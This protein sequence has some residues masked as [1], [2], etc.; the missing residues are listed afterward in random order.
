MLV[1]ELK[2][3]TTT[4][5][6]S[7]DKV[8]AISFLGCSCACA[9]PKGRY[10]EYYKY[11]TTINHPL[12]HSQATQI[13]QNLLG[14]QTI[15]GVDL[16]ALADEGEDGRGGRE[17]GRDPASHDGVLRVLFGEPFERHS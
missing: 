1:I 16:E 8:R 7:S 2:T 12:S 13:I 3:S 11:E 15:R 4:S 14:R 17:V 6:S 5:F 9:C 10:V